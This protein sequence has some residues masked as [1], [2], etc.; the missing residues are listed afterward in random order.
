MSQA[1]AGITV[2]DACG[3]AMG[4]Y[5]STRLADMGARVIKIEHPVG[6][7]RGRGIT[8]VKHVAMGSYNWLHEANNRGKQSL[9]VNWKTEKGR[10]VLCRLIAAAD[11]FMTNMK[12]KTMAKSGLDYETLTKTNPKI[13]YAHCTGWGSKG[14]YANSDA[15]DLNAFARSGLMSVMGEP[16]A[17]PA[18]L[19]PGA[20]D[21]TAGMVLAYGI[22][23]ALF[24]RER[25]GEGQ[26]L[27]VSLLNTMLTVFG[28]GVLQPYLSNSMKH[29]Y[30]SRINPGNALCNTYQTKDGRWLMLSMM[31]G[32]AP[33][34]EFCGLLGMNELVH[35]PRFESYDARCQNASA[36]REIFDKAFF[37]RTLSQWIECFE[38]HDFPWS[39]CQTVEEVASDP[40]VIENES[41]IT[42]NHPDQG[43]L[44]IVGFQVKFDKT[45]A[46]IKSSAPE[47]GQ[48]TEEILLEL[49]YN[50]EE[51]TM[52][53]E[54]KVII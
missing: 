39:P 2:V 29:V 10:D 52:L 32:D 22:V 6:G 33:W 11:V 53:K 3:F 34:P 28:L 17:P 1:L 48:N 50:W 18:K 37:S 47:L 5:A 35:D 40:Q 14:P 43:P 7:D 24:H 8:S 38:G 36:L 16:D 30:D 26:K 4:P 23:T 42:H 9:A 15:F 21:M 45:P 44:K 19:I 49:G 54:T 25:T 31:Q 12:P 27:E 41:I 51:I 13:I 46:E 20:G